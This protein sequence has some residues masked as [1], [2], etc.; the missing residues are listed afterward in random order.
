VLLGQLFEHL[1]VGGARGLGALHHG[2]LELV[3]EDGLEL[4][5]GVD[6]EG[7]AREGV[8]LASRAG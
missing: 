6:V 7:L 1:G 2:Q 3:E 5:R 4:P 8:A